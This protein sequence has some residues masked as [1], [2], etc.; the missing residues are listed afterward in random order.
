MV[1]RMVLFTLFGG[2]ILITAKTMT[3]ALTASSGL[4]LGAGL[5]VFSLTRTKFDVTREGFFYTPD[6]WIGIAVTA[7]FVGRLIARFVTVY[8]AVSHLEPGAAPP[9]DAHRSVVTGAL[10]L[11]MVGYY[12]AYNVGILRKNHMN[13]A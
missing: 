2:F 11:L 13:P 4:V 6:K 9:L 12:G 10:V 1:L 8:Q 3:G 7:L 5:G